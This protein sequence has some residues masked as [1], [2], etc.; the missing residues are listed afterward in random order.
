MAT[1]AKRR[2][3]SLHHRLENL[4]N[5]MQQQL[6]QMEEDVATGNL[7]NGIT[8]RIEELDY[9]QQRLRKELKP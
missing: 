3:R 1:E 4:A 8:A 9:W 2:P 7:T 5:Q 6:Q